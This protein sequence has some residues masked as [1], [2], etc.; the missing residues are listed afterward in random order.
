MLPKR[1]WAEMTWADFRDGNPAEWIAVLPVA[2][3]EQHG[4]HL[5]L[6][7]DAMI[8]EGYLARVQALVPD[9]LP[10]TFLP[11]QPVGKSDEHIFFPGTLTLAP[12]VATQAWIDLGESVHRA[13][14][15]K[16][17]IVNSHGGNSALLELVAR[18]LRVHAGMFVTTAGWSRFGYPAGLFSD[19]EIKHGIHGGEI[20]TS[21]MLALKPELVRMDRA[22]DFAPAT[23]AMERE[24]KWL[25]ADRPAGFGWTAQDLHPA[26]AI[27]NAKAATREK[28][29]AVLEHG[30]RA[31]AELLQDVEQFDVTRLN[32]GPRG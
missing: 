3:V 29:E 28:G 18:A 13:G 7:V 9:S 8:A 5:P 26:G 21:I 32:D 11:L 2:A 4:P 10:V 19:A 17:V 27:G 14:V 30:A 22:E 15:Q 20:E 23:H 12:E 24:F 25:R 6:G 31:F 1:Q 16:L